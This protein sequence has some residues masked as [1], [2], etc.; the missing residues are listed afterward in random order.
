[1][2]GTLRAGLLTA[3]LLASCAKAPEQPSPQAP[4]PSLTLTPVA[5]DAVP[6]WRQDRLTEALPA[7]RR[8]CA[9]LRAMAPDASLGG[10]PV[11]PHGAHP[12]DWARLCTAA[13]AMRTADPDAVRNMLERELRPYQIADHGQPEG[14]FTGYY[15]PQLDGALRRGG[16]YQT[17]LLRRPAD[18]IQVDLGAFDTDLA[19]R[20][21]FGHLSGNR[22]VPYY[23][24][25]QIE[26]GALAGQH[27]D[28][29]FVTDPI[30]AFFLEIQGS[31]RVRLADGRVLRVTY[32]GQNGRPYVPIGRLL[33][34][35]GALV[36]GQV[37]MQTIRSW[38]EAHP[39]EAKSVMDA[40]PSYVFFRQERGLPPNEGA[41]GALGVPLSPGRSLAVDPHYL[42][43]GAPVFVATT[44]AL[45]GA[46]WQ[47]LLLAQDRGGAI[48][49]PV[50]GDIFFGWGAEA[51]ALAG[52]MQQPGT[53]YLLL[54]R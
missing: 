31:G 41:P 24:R 10:A 21:I 34:E 20:S 36:H 27:L 2:R 4:A 15:E 30:A 12:A 35:R 37:S 43:L 9:V 42:P 19:G 48:K 7:L 45:D 26:A 11:V 49:G 47:H 39:T 16:R 44:N 25:S 5:F 14:L 38:L 6:G 3:L 46:P 1:M 17:P 23:D 52:R 54:P 8:E 33:V 51:E 13:D 18:L 28:L 22:L 29:L 32:D 53:A 50:R 40:N